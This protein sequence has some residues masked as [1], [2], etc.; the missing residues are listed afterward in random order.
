MRKFLKYFLTFLLGLLI[1][2]A[3]LVAIFVFAVASVEDST[4]EVEVHENS[5]I[6]L[7][8]SA[9]IE[10]RVEEDEFSKVFNLISNTSNLGLNELTLLFK[11]AAIDKNING[12][13]LDAGL[14]AGGYATAN[15]IRNLIH[16]FR[17]TD[18]FI[19]CY[20]ENYTEQGYYIASACDSIFFEPKWY[21]RIE[22]PRGRDHHV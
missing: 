20:S 3:G 15:E 13:Y 4:E 7:K 19:Y 14:Y 17:N 2:T 10:D 21:V 22:W 5:V 6:S 18:K 8:L 1:G 12:I 16:D 9:V 11:R